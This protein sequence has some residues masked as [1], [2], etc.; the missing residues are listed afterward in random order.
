[1]ALIATVLILI[2]SITISNKSF[3]QLF[4]SGSNVLN[5]GIGLGSSFGYG[6]T[7]TSDLGYNLSFEHGIKDGVGPGNLGIGIKVSHV[8]AHYKETSSGYQYKWNWSNNVVALR[9]TYHPDF[10]SGDKW[11]VYGAA[12]AGLDIWKETYSDNDP[13]SI[14][15]YNSSAS[16]PVIYFQVGGRY[17]L[18]NAIGVFAELGYDVTYA[19]GGI[20]IN[21]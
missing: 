10:L 6:Y 18:T 19:K 11:E 1:M 15:D 16:T 13:N 5:L 4:S 9:V 20:C 17:Y 12:D 14:Y 3:A 7:A 8:G 21:L 2:L